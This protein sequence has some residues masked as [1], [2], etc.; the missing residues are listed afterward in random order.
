MKSRIKFFLFFILLII[1][2]LIYTVHMLIWIDNNTIFSVD[3]LT[4]EQELFIQQETDVVFP[5]NA[6][7]DKVYFYDTWGND[8]LRT[9]MIEIIMPKK[10]YEELAKTIPTTSESNKSLKLI[11]END[12]STR[13]ELRYYVHGYS[14]LEEFIKKSGYENITY[15]TIYAIRNLIPA[16]LISFIPLIPYKKISNLLKL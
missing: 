12:N 3:D 13:V 1:V 2:L 5:S 6:T 11:K 9:F 16:I 7:I 8:T 14:N 15:K 4:L 10:S